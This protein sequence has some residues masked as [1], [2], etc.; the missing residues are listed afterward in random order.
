MSLA[1][2]TPEMDIIGAG[3]SLGAGASALPPDLNL[4]SIR[5]GLLESTRLFLGTTR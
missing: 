5:L 1:K 3:D 4:P 2:I